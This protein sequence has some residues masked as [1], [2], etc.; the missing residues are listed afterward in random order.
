MCSF[1]VC[2]T[3]QIDIIFFKKKIKELIWYDVNIMAVD[4]GYFKFVE[5]VLKC[6]YVEHSYTA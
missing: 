5:N 2:A 4:F 1:I 6:T 3:L